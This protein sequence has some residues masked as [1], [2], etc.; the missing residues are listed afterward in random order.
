MKKKLPAAAMAVL[1]LL[2]A[3]GC[4]APKGEAGPVK[5]ATKPMTEQY[6][7]GEMLGLLIED[8]GYTVEITKG[9]GGGTSNIQPAMEKGEFDL[10]P[11]YTS[12]GYVMVLDHDAAGVTDDEIWETLR[13]EYHDKYRMAWVGQY[14]F[15]N[16]FTVAVRAAAAEEYGIRTCSDLGRASGGLVFGGNPDYIERADGFNLLCETYGM[17]FKDVR[18]IDIG[19]KYAALASGDIDVTNAFTTDAQ[20]AVADVV[21]LEDDLR[22]QVNYFCA[23]V[24][25]EDALE[26]YPGLEDALKKMEGILTDQEM[27]ALN[28]QVE[29]EERGERDV[30]RAF[31]ASKGLLEE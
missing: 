4:G 5:I 12:T 6:I 21:T 10:Y 28:Y 7:L 20:L 29:V 14:G 1:L 30:A 23:T 18:D 8:A 11:E 22:L 26:K 31:L 25:R 3:A 17:D 27:A 19:L 13:T 15:N 16:T 2:S 24:V 9:I